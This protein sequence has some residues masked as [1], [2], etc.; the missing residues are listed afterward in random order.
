MNVGRMATTMFNNAIM[1]DRSIVE[2]AVA[3]VNGGTSSFTMAVDVSAR[4]D[5]WAYEN[6]LPKW[7]GTLA[8]ALEQS[9]TLA[10][11]DVDCVNDIAPAFGAIAFGDVG[12]KGLPG[13]YRDRFL[14]QMPQ[15]GIVFGWPSYDEV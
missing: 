4:D 14:S 1:V 9:N 15:E 10:S 13:P 2:G 6:W 8:I 3:S 11:N 7:P 12:S 5:Q